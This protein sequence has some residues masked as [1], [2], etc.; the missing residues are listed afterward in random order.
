MQRGG[1]TP[2]FLFGVSTLPSGE[3][4]GVG[5]AGAVI[6]YTNGAWSPFTTTLTANLWAVQALSS[7]E[8]YI[9]GDHLIAR[10]DSS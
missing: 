6:R 3:T 7:N 10:C 8:V 4:W 2:Q 9:A 1:P 5:Y